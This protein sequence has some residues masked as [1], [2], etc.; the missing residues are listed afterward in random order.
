MREW[1]YTRFVTYNDKYQICIINISHAFFLF[2][3]GNQIL[4]TCSNYVSMMVIKSY[5]I[6]KTFAPNVICKSSI[7]SPAYITRMSTQLLICSRFFWTFTV[8]PK[9]EIACG[10]LLYGFIKMH[11][12]LTGKQINFRSTICFKHIAFL[13]SC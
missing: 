10:C 2:T 8:H 9:L 11:T 13:R 1:V 5:H 4:C 12:L 3:W 7:Q 6:S